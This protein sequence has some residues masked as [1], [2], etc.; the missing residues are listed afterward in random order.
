M[1]AVRCLV[2]PLTAAMVL[3][4][5]YGSVAVPA[6]RI[7][8]TNA[9]GGRSGDVAVGDDIEVR[10]T[11]YRDGSRRYTWAAAPQSGGPVLLRTA[12]ATTP[13]GGVSAV[14]RAKQHGVAEISAV[15]KCL[16]DPGHMCPLLIVPWKVTVRVK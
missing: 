12:D 1:K 4:T 8:L 14:F 7:T 9:D 6:E 2:A 10:L 13:K 5:G 11:P 16:A 3:M 15:R